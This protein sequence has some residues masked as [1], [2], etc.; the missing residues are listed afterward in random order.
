MPVDLKRKILLLEINEIPWRV[1]DKFKNDNR[2][3]NINYYFSKSKNFTTI[4]TDINQNPP[5]EKLVHG[6]SRDNVPVAINSDELSPWVTWPTFHRGISSKNHKIKFLGQDV[7]TFQGKPIWQEFLERGYNIG[8]CGSLQS[9]PPLNPGDGGFYIPDT[10]AH[11][12]KCMPA[13]IGT[14]QKFNLEQV[15]K[16]GLVIRKNQLISKELFKLLCSLPRLGI[17]LKTYFRVIWQLVSESFNK[18]MVARRPVFQCIILW[19]IFKSLYSVTNP[20]AFSSFFT[21]HFASLI[22]RYWSNVFPEDFN[23]NINDKNKSSYCETVI[24]GLKI[25]DEIIGEVI[26]FC[27]VNPDITVVFASSMGQ[28]AIKYTAFEGYSAELENIDKLFNWFNIKKNEYKSQLAM[29]PQFAIEVLNPKVK[30]KIV[31]SVN[32]CFTVSGNKLFTVE[33]AGNTLSI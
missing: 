32:G 5:A 26:Q 4:V 27:N 11:D 18:T 14:F 3:A 19:D 13:Y 31:N 10:F 23:E 28:D 29:V 8:M 20:P 2:F 7:S 24:Y 22:H 33:E 9:W 16:N 30:E 1:I 17:T 25:I 15:Q 21:N 6:L 12:P